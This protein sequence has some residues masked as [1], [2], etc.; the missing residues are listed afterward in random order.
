[1]TGS[2]S[3]VYRPV[4]RHD[5]IVIG[6]GPAG[7]A[8]ALTAARTGLSVAL[9]DRRSFPRDKLCGGGLTGRCIAAAERLLGHPLPDS[10][11]ERR[12][13]FEFRAHGAPLGRV[14]GVPPIHLTTRREFDAYLQRSAIAAG[15]EDWSG[16]KPTAI[17][18]ARCR[19]TLEDG[20]ALEGRLI[21]GADGVASSTARALFGR[22]YDPA[23]VGFA[24]EVEAPPEPGAPD[25]VRIDF[26]AAEWGYGWQFPKSESATIGVGGLHARNPQMRAA[27]ERYLQDL[28]VDPAAQRVKGAFLP[29]GAFRR[30][31]GRGRVLLAGDAAG[32]VDPVTGEGLAHAIDSGRM[33]AEAAAAAL[34]DGRAEAA[35]PLYRDSLRPI[36]RAL[37]YARALRLVIYASPLRAGFIRAFRTS[38]TLR[39]EYLRMLGGEREYDEIAAALLRRLPRHLARSLGSAA[40]AR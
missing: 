38:R 31:P 10:L 18:P 15:A 22:A 2:R 32:L 37:R 19:V 24:M 7:A 25:W 14:E 27:L 35:L 21:V 34:A 3:G 9:I 13:S 40:R 6:A 28:G 33:A 4:A 23:R 29:F 39:D 20:E 12:G 5:V 8:A 36:H 26:G 11:A 30:V 17:D 16:R 1:M